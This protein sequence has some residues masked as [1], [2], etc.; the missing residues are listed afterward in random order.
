MSDLD[1][2]KAGKAPPLAH[3]GLDQADLASL[4]HLETASVAA[5]AD[6]QPKPVGLGDNRSPVLIAV[7]VLLVISF[8]LNIVQ[9]L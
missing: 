4:S 1:E 3:R 8:V 5:P 6:M 7:I 2:V 9:L